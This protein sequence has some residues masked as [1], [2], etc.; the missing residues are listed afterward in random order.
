MKFLHG[1][2]H[3]RLPHLGGPHQPCEPKGQ[4]SNFSINT[5]SSP[6]LT[7]Y[8]QWLYQGRGHQAWEVNMPQGQSWSFSSVGTM[9]MCLARRKNILPTFALPMCTW[10]MYSMPSVHPRL[11]STISEG[12]FLHILQCPQLP[13]TSYCQRMCSTTSIILELWLH[14]QVWPLAIHAAELL[15]LEF[16]AHW[17]PCILHNH[18]ITCF[19]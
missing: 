12:D 8:G 2:A 17:F 1:P 19:T 15:Y 4:P 16:T 14:V 6:T 7:W 5:S 10:H 18:A 9:L 13:D 3:Q 11:P